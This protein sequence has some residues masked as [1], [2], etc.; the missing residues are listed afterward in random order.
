M[1]KTSKDLT[2]EEYNEEVFYCNSCHSLHI[3]V[4]DTLAGED[5]DGSYCAKCFSSDIRKC[6]FGQWL[7]IEEWKEEK[8]RIKEWN[9]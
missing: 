8:K 5:W 4:D 7:E 1:K 9:R 2:P 3:V 6:K